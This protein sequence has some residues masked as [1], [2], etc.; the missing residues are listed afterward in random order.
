[1]LTEPQS[2]EDGGWGPL[3]PSQGAAYPENDAGSYGHC[4]TF[5]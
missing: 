3:L 2:S 5:R 1:M 4:G